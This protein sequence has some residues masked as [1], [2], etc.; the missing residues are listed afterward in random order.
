M[1][2]PELRSAISSPMFDMVVA[3]MVS[4]ATCRALSCHGQPAADTAS[5]F[6]TLPCLQAKKR[7]VGVAIERDAQVVL[8]AAAAT[9]FG[10]DFGM[11]RP[12]VLVDVA[13]IRLIVDE[14]GLN[15]ARAKYFVRHRRGRA[16]RAIDQHVQARKLVPFTVAASHSTYC[17]KST[18]SVAIADSGLAFA[19][20]IDFNSGTRP[21]SRSKMSVSICSSSSSDSL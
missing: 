17:R 8:P 10:D 6:T 12:A 5:P 13:P 20:G 1:R 14:I 18:G 11:Q 21:C 2:I 3:T 16:V 7:A 4:A 19:A 9:A 15:A